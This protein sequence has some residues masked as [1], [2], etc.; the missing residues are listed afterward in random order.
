MIVSGGWTPVG[1][2]SDYSFISYSSFLVSDSS[3]RL[4]CGRLAMLIQNCWT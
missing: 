3:I 2:V 4:Y 1:L